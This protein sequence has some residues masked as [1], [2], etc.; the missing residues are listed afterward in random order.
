[1]RNLEVL[2]S[3]SSAIDALTASPITPAMMKQLDAAHT[4]Y[5]SAISYSLAL[6]GHLLVKVTAL[7]HEILD[8]S[9]KC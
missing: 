5:Y 3:K 2:V 6:K 9:V 4:R 7:Q 1:M 8:H